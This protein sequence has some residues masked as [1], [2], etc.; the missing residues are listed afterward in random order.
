MAMLFFLKQLHICWLQ[1]FTPEYIAELATPS[2]RKRIIIDGL[3]CVRKGPSVG[4]NPLILFTGLAECHHNFGWLRRP[5]ASDPFHRQQPWP[6]IHLGYRVRPPFW[7]IQVVFFCSNSGGRVHCF[8]HNTVGARSGLPF[9]H[10]Y[11]QR[12]L[13]SATKTVLNITLA[14]H[15]CRFTVVPG[16]LSLHR[17]NLLDPWYNSF[18]ARPSESSAQ[19]WVLS[20]PWS[21]S[22]VGEGH[23]RRSLVQLRDVLQLGYNRGCIN[24]SFLVFGA[25]QGILDYVCCDH[26]DFHDSCLVFW[27]E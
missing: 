19:H 23:F 2:S 25:G 1:I 9:H 15:Y 17:H 7:Q 6:F 20:L 10:I 21:Q 5:L 14:C 18:C 22:A 13:S 24:R 16:V 27:T 11:W 4:G 12:K 26:W 3:K 8:L